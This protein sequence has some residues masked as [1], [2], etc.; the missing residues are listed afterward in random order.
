MSFNPLA[1]SEG[2]LWGDIARELIADLERSM[3]GGTTANT[4][5]SGPSLTPGVLNKMVADMCGKFP[6]KPASDSPLSFLRLPNIEL[7]EA[8][9][10]RPKMQL[11]RELMVSDAFRAEFDAWLLERFGYEEDA[12]SGGKSYLIGN[13]YLVARDT[14]YLAAL[15]NTDTGA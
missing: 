2:D 10:R 7:I 4:S 1:G 14:R 12:F 11:S 5:S 6:T 9:P 8:P 13:Q 15:I 3:F